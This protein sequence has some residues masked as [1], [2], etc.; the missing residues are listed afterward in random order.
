MTAPT[1]RIPATDQV[2]HRAASYNA[3]QALADLS[4][5]LDQHLKVRLSIGPADHQQRVKL[6]VLLYDDST[7]RQAEWLAHRL[8]LTEH[9]TRTTSR[10]GTLHIWAGTFGGY[11]TEVDWIAKPGAEL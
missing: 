8:G 10:G 3:A 6:G 9:I 1:V 4:K 5:H 7:Y 2:D 11:V